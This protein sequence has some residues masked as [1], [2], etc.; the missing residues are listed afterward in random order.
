MKTKTIITLIALVFISEKSLAQLEVFGK[1]TDQNGTGIPGVLVSTGRI[2]NLTDNKGRFEVYLQKGAG[3][4]VFKHPEF[5]NSSLYYG[6]ND[7]D[8][9][10]VSMKPRKKMDSYSVQVLNKLKPGEIMPNIKL[11][12]LANSRA[13][14][15]RLS[16]DTEKV[17][18]LVFWRASSDL[19]LVSKIDYITWYAGSGIKSY[20]VNN[21]DS[22]EV[23]SKF[24]ISL[25]KRLTFPVMFGGSVLAKIFDIQHRSFAVWLDRDRKIIA[26]TGLEDV[27]KKNVDAAIKG[28]YGALQ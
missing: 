9:I 2:K 23:I 27:T 21:G 28:K 12:N 11:K 14:S 3:Q 10:S 7:A 18:L 16:A 26:I 17:H 20:F 13:L 25:N 8:F 19:S 5:I 24:L 22:P 15:M 1:V 6:R 4:I